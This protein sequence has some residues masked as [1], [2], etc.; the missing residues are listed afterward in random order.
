MKLFR[1]ISFVAAL[2]LPV[3]ALAAG[4]EHYDGVP[5]G[6][7]GAHAFNVVLLFGAIIYFAKTPVREYFANKR[8]SFLAEAEKSQASRLAAE[9][10]RQDIQN[11]LNHLEATA[12]ESI[13]RA[14]AEAQDLKRQLVTEAESN[15]TRLKNE[16]K[17]AAQAEIQRAKDSIRAALISD[18]IKEARNKVQTGVTAEDQARMESK[19]LSNIQAVQK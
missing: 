13:A 2:V 8:T 11:K 5:W 10:A 15:S 14:R 6:K 17:S 3:F 9:K 1:K 18:S 12:A 16:A 19:F 7:V 4:G